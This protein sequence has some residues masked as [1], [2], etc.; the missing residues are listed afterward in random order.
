MHKGGTATG[1]LSQGGAEALRQV[2]DEIGW[3]LQADVQPHQ[4]AAVPAVNDGIGER[5]AFVATPRGANSE[6]AGY[7]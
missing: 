3:I 5:Q 2:G 4:R 1:R 7:R 6:Q